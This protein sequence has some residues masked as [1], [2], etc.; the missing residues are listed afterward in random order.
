MT[1]TLY[2]EYNAGHNNSSKTGTVDVPHVTHAR[3]SYT[4]S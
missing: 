3:I 1:L 2:D 4:I